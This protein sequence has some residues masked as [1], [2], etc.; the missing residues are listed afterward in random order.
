MNSKIV[1]VVIYMKKCPD[2]SIFLTTIEI[3]VISISLM[4]N[5]LTA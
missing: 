3:I 5:I 2:K 4:T 1:S